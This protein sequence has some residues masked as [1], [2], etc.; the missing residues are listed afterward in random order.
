MLS[1]KVAC[2]YKK[3]RFYIFTNSEP[4]STEESEEG[5]SNRDI[6]NEKP[7]KEDQITAFEVLTVFLYMFTLLPHSPLSS[8]LY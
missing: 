1:I 8:L 5:A 3:N 7:K 6:F 4:Y 2:A